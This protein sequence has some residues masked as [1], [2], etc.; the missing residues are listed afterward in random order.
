MEET[1]D[2][3]EQRIRRLETELKLISE[4]KLIVEVE[5]SGDTPVKKDLK[6][7]VLE[8]HEDLE[9]KIFK[10]IGKFEKRF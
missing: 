10:Q 7:F 8:E 6:E 5:G 3:F 1:T 9:P 4:E 2:A